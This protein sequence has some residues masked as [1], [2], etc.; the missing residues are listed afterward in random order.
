MA[1]KSLTNTLVLS[2]ALILGAGPYIVRA[3]GNHDKPAAVEGQAENG[4]T[5]CVDM[6]RVYAESAAKQKVVVKIREFGTT[7]F[8]RFEEL[9]RL[10][11]LTMDELN[12]YSEALFAQPQTD[13]QKQKMTSL[14]AES[15][16]RTEEYQNL[17]ATKDADLTPADRT[18]L[19]ELNGIAQKQPQVFGQMQAG[20]R[21]LVN[22]EEERLTR[23]GVSEVR[24]IVSKLAKEQGFTYVYD[25][26]ALVVAPVDLTLKAIERVQPKK[27]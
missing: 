19:R 8:Q 23:Q 17:S 4:K 9:T 3:A 10:S 2:A 16:K 5:A 25:S 15:A 14:R 18:R 21:Q 6:A 1:R 22:E 26:N 27:K 20:A 7:V 24:D 13:A 12:D 11:Y